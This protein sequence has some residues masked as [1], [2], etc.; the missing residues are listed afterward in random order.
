ME[1]LV[2][3]AMN[4]DWDAFASLI[5]RH[6]ESMYKTAWI[7]LRNDQ[8]AADAI[9]ETILTCYEKIQTLKNPSA[10]KTWLL[11]ILKNK[12]FDLLRQ[13]A[14]TESLDELPSPVHFHDPVF[15]EIEWKELLQCLDPISAEIIEL[16]FFDDLT[17]SEI[18][19]VMDMNRNT[20]L[21]RLRRAKEKLREIYNMT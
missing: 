2:R 5:E 15:G 21:T 1:V 3:Q 17:A 12:C 7:F 16:H 6:K 19:E 14:K 4:G 8:D 18:A 20:V 11:R 9:Q 10:F 13:T